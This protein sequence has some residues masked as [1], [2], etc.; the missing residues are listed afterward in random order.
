MK[1]T[2]GRFAATPGRSPHG[3]GL[4][5]DVG[6]GV[7]RFGSPQHV[8]MQQNAHLFGWEHPPWARQGGS[9]PE[10]WHWEFPGTS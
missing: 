1:R 4:A 5:L 8:W 7:N 6:C 10:A 9:L 2:R 3:W